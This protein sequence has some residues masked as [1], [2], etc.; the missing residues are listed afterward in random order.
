M[1]ITEEDDPYFKDT[2]DL[3]KNLS[4]TETYT[5]PKGVGHLAPL[6]HP[7]KFFGFLD[8]FLP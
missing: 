1:V 3:K 4:N 7:D 2:D 5:F 8:D 6:I